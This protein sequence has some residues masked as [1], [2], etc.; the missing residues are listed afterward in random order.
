MPPSCT[1]STTLK[2]SVQLLSFPN[3]WRTLSQLFHHHKV[4]VLPHLDFTEDLHCD[5]RHLCGWF[6]PQACKWEISTVSGFQ[7]PIE[8]RLTPEINLTQVTELVAST[9]AFKLAPNKRTDVNT[10][11]Q[12]ALGCTWLCSVMETERVYETER[13]QDSAGIPFKNWTQVTSLLEALPKELSILKTEVHNS[14]QT[15]KEL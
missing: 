3:L 13:V 8:F 2:T 9:W 1:L 14:G 6:L 11:S 7:Q 12:Y 10:D 4:S 15:P 5:P